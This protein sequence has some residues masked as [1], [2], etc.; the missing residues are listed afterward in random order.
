MTS[1]ELSDHISELRWLVSELGNEMQVLETTAYPLAHRF[2]MH[3]L[4]R[5]IARV[6]AHTTHCLNPSLATSVARSEE[7]PVELIEHPA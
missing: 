7:Q 6:A 4:A 3:R 5:R 1:P 2:L